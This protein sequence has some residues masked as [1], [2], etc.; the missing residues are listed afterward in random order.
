MR[1]YTGGTIATPQV[2]YSDDSA[3]NGKGRLASVAAA[4]VSTYNYTAYDDMG[5]VTACNQAITGGMYLLDVS[6]IQPGGIAT[7]SDSPTTLTA[8][9]RVRG[10]ELAGRSSTSR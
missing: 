7:G 5:R 3:A 6:D 1:T 4:G 9:V 10:R 2:T 8:S